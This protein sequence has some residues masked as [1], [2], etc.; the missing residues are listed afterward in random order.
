VPYLFEPVPP[1]D[2]IAI[3]GFAD[4]VSSLTH[5]VG[6]LIA[7]VAGVP[8]VWR[9]VRAKDTLRS[10]RHR[11]RI[12][13]LVIFVG[14]AVLLLSMSGVYH[15]MDRHSPGR[16]VMQRL[17]HAAIF[18]LIAG[19]AT[20]VYAIMFR[21]GWRWGMLTLLWVLAFVGVTLKSIY[22]AAF[23][24]NVGVVLYIA[25][26]WLAG[27]SMVLLAKRYGVAFVLPLLLGGVVYT[28]GAVVEM[29]E[30]R[31]LLRAVF[32]SHELFHLAVLGGLTWQWRFIW[33]IA[34]MEG[35]ESREE[36]RAA[37]RKRPVR[38]SRERLSVVAKVASGGNP[39]TLSHAPHHESLESRRSAASSARTG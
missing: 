27:I 14:S 29:I 19:T 1:S 35:D 5:L 17:D 18:F 38:A 6:A 9:G 22:F 37:A 36:A 34:A 8:L 21:G 16:A 2:L 31:P 15:L 20:P 10:E 28:L 4:P 3:P 25:M 24:Q 26:G 7:L 33:L 30:P 11:L 32:R 23:P 12:A 13:S 39:P